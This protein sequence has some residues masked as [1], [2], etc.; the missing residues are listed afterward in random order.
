MSTPPAHKR[1][2]SSPSGNSPTPATEGTSSQAPP[3]PLSSAEVDLLP[4][5]P[6]NPRKRPRSSVSP[7]PTS[8]PLNTL[9]PPTT[10][11]GPSSGGAPVSAL[12][13][14]ESSK[15]KPRTNT[16]WTAQEEQTLKRMRDE[17]KSWGEIA[18]VGK[19]RAMQRRPPALIH[20]SP[21]RTGQKAVLRNIGT[22]YSLHG[23]SSLLPAYP[24]QDMHY[25]DWQEDEVSASNKALLRE[26]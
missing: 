5:P 22:R 24:G 3:P 18:K 1:H 17:G 4:P 20:C 10:P 9:P 11:L 26:R 15:K 2:K 6:S 19:K 16:P 14:E 23:P 12:L 8:K 7:L 13:R 25:A 21:F